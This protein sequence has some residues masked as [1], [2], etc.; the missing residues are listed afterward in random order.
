MRG[1]K[2]G[3]QPRTNAHTF[4]QNRHL[5]EIFVQTCSQTHTKTVLP[6]P[7][8]IAH[9]HTVSIKHPIRP[10]PI[11]SLPTSSL[12]SHYK[13][14]THLGVCGHT[15]QCHY[16]GSN[17]LVHVCPL[18]WVY[19]L[20]VSSADGGFTSPGACYWP[21][22]TVP[23]SCV[24]SIT[25][26][27]QGNYWRTLGEQWRVKRN[28]VAISW[29]KRWTFTSS[30]VDKADDHH[31]EGLCCSAAPIDARCFC[32]FLYEAAI[33]YFYFVDPDNFWFVNKM[34]Q[35]FYSN[36]HKKKKVQVFLF[37]VT[38]HTSYLDLLG[39]KIILF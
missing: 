29:K 4:T 28:T 23:V 7:D 35:H 37:M 31:Q 34:W 36:K 11:I 12:T 13:T 32:M 16:S 25:S 17:R 9:T 24:K 33:K 30:S 3:I 8:I 39:S 5:Q 19:L 6:H 1:K 26:W 14:L 21:P 10:H 15:P 2:R 22:V 18:L 27:Q 38:G 20:G